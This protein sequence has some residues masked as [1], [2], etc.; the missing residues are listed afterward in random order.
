MT[1]GEVFDRE[2]GDDIIIS[3]NNS[4]I[5]W[6]ISGEC[7]RAE[8]PSERAPSSTT[9]NEPSTEDGMLHDAY[10]ISCCIIVLYYFLFCT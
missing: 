5:H 7:M 2:L 6:K 10:S 3:V 4:H 9:A 1:L 8:L